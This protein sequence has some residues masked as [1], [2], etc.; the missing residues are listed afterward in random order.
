MNLVGELVLQKNRIAAISRTCL[1]TDAPQELKEALTL[2]ASGLDRVTGD[3]QLAVMRTRMQPLEKLFGKYPRLIRDLC[4]KTGKKIKLEIEG[5]DTEVDKSVIEELGDPLVHLLR[6]SAD[7]GIEASADRVAAGKSETGTIRLL[8]AHQGSHVTVK[9]IDDGRGLNKERILRKAIERGL[10]QESA[11]STLSERD[12]FQFIFLPGF[13][14][15]EK[16]SDL[17]GRGVGMDVVRTNI[18]KVKGTISLSS[19]PGKG[20]EITIT[21]P[22]TIAI[23]QAMMVSSGDEIYALP[24]ANILEIVKPSKE[25]LSTIGEHPVM[26]LRDRILPLIPA[27]EIFGTRDTE[28]VTSPFAVVLTMNDKCVGLMVSGLIGQQEIVIKPLD[29]LGVDASS[30]GR[31]VSGATVRDDGGVSLIV[32]VAELVR[33]AE[34]RQIKGL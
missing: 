1:G 15:A 27:T 6:N 34:T 5:G 31:S 13:S 17:S 2:N 28:K 3:I 25:S 16:V 7:H 11:V 29:T 33:M 26:R 19:E 20:T 23:M 22:L 10:V 18:E 14:T 4:A 24:L 8:A 12:I 30:K 32:D 21:I 9:V